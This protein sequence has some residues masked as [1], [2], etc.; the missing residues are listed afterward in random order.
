MKF[1]QKKYFKI[2]DF[3]FDYFNMINEV[4]NKINISSLKKIAKLI[5]NKIKNNKNIYICGNG[6]SA[7]I[8]NHY[9]ADYSKVLRTN[10]RLKPKLISLLSNVELIT[11]ISNDLSYDQI[12]SYQLETLATKGDLLIL[13]SSS[14]NSKNLINAL[15]I[16]KKKGIKTISFVGFKGGYLKKNSDLSIH[17]KIDNYGI[18]E[19][20]AQLLMHVIVQF[21]RQKNL[22][23]STK[24]VKF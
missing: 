16:A 6:G 20:V 13:I 1:P 11:A 23:N 10:T 18:S 3:S 7:A 5:E 17:A 8:S 21:L 12:F 14:G 4:L 2:D 15:K 19:D 22:I 9:V 24:R